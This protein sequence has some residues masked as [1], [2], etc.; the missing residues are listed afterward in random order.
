MI[1]L[2][3]KGFLKNLIR[4]FFN[5]KIKTKHILFIHKNVDLIILN[6]PIDQ[7]RPLSH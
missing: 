3:K 7:D 2:V 4:R 5:K 1:F 6:H